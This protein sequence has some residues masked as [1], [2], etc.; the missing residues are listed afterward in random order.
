MSWVATALMKL[1]PAG[2]R[3]R[4]AARTRSVAMADA[5]S[6]KRGRRSSG[7][8][9]F[10][11]GLVLGQDGSCRILGGERDGV[12]FTLVERPSRRQMPGGQVA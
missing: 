1:C 5:L 9:K 10:L 3:S 7:A 6:S 4:S 2:S 11:H 12:G 8:K